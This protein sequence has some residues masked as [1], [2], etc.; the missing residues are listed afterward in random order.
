MDRF[1][2]NRIDRNLEIYAKIAN[3]FVS[4]HGFGVEYDKRIHRVDYIGS[5]QC[6]DLVAELMPTHLIVD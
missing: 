6:K 5:D 4:K 2:I 1:L 3:S